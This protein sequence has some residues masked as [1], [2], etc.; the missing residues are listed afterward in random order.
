[1]IHGNNNHNNNGYV[2]TEMRDGVAKL[3]LLKWVRIYA[4]GDNG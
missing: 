4:G 2:I 3:K 1:M